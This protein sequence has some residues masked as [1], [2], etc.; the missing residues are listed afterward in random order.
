MLG[1]RITL[2]VS[3]T[4]PHLRVVLKYFERV[5]RLSPQEW[6]LVLAAFDLLGRATVITGRRRLSFRKFYER[7]IEHRY[8]D[9]FLDS[10][11]TSDDPE[12][13]NEAL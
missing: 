8:A 7:E 2:P 5:N 3:L 4:A 6:K 13:A 1:A 9:K 12:A 11:L 10:L